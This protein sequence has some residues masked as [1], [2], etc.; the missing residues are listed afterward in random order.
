[1]WMVVE[2]KMVPGAGA[3]MTL[4]HELETLLAE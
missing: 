1:M 2:I 4:S 3:S